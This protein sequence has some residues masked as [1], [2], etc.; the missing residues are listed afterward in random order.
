MNLTW[1]RC[2]I[3]SP[4][5]K[6]F[7]L[8]LFS[9]TSSTKSIVRRICTTKAESRGYEG[10]DSNIGAQISDLHKALIEQSR[11]DLPLKVWKSGVEIQLVIIDIVFKI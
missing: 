6:N 3:V 4:N 11:L 10:D 5:L 9:S 1:F 8:I 2:C 7:L